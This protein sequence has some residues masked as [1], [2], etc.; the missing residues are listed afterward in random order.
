LATEYEP[1]TQLFLTINVPEVHAELRT[2]RL[3]LDREI[4]SS[5]A[6]AAFVNAKITNVSVGVARTERFLT[7]MKL[8]F[9][10]I[11]VNDMYEKTDWPLLKTV[12]PPR[13]SYT[14]VIIL[15]FK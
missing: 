2:K 13:F 15:F 14:L 8:G 1:N 4:P 7:K 3:S 11:V 10:D 12:P 5:T 6:S 9:D